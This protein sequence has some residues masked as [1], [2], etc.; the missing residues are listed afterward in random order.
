MT[1]D[2]DMRFNRCSLFRKGVEKSTREIYANG[3]C[4]QSMR[5][6]LEQFKK[7][8]RGM[9]DANRN[10]TEAKAESSKKA[11][12]NFD[13]DVIIS[14]LLE[15][16]TRAG[17][18]K[19]RSVDELDDLIKKAA[20]CSMDQLSNLFDG[21]E[22][23]SSINNDGKRPDFILRN[24]FMAVD[25]M[26]NDFYAADCFEVNKTEGG[27]KFNT[28]NQK[29]VNENVRDN[30]SALSKGSTM[31]DDKN[32]EK[33]IGGKREDR[34]EGKSLVK[35]ID[36]DLSPLS[37]DVLSRWG[38]EILQLRDLGFLNDHR[39]VEALESLHAA[40]IGVDSSDQVTIEKAANYILEQSEIF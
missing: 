12:E 16:T 3:R 35:G 25:A 20:S 14:Q 1:S 6:K 11:S 30:T 32:D 5:E 24:F 28:R 29:H 37:P 2:R 26:K 7:I 21:V 19:E 22:S 10:R 40:N 13:P 8:L 39:S 18:K 4:D 9:A 36:Y 27:V 33:K 38:V 15:L 23:N 31:P 17:T 34:R